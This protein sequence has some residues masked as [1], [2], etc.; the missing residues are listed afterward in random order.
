MVAL[1]ILKRFLRWLLGFVPVV[2][3]ALYI[4]LV[5]IA[6]KSDSIIFQPQPSSYTDAALSAM[7]AR[8]NPAGRVVHLKSGGATIAAF[9]LPNPQARYTLLFSHGNAEDIGQVMFFLQPFY[10]AG[11]SIMAYDYRGYG[12]SSGKPSEDGVYSDAN[13]T[14][15]YVTQEL[16]LPPNQIIAM[17]RSL[18]SAAAIHL[19]ATRPV[20]GLIAEAPFLSA[21][22]VL[23]RMQILPWDK[24]NNAREIR[25]VHVPVLIVHGSGD[26]VVPFWHGRRLYELA[27]EPKT[28]MPVLGAGHNDIV[29]L[30]GKKYIQ[31]LQTF[32][33]EL[34]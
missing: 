33:A 22:R 29:L 8:S 18:G 19:A 10:D 32:A 21:F 15:D 11:F 31:A 30:A 23:T 1:Q 13:A 7:L 27:H 5:V 26:Q 34:K 24:F 20:A 28:F 4:S 6:V 14:Y 16:H 3:G 9:Y 25:N 2:F 17:G 12:T